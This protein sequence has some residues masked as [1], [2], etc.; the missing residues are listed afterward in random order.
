MPAALKTKHEGEFFAVDIGSTVLKIAQVAPD[1]TL[2]AQA[3]NNRDY[4]AEIVDQLGD[5]LAPLGPRI[6]SGNLVICSSA[7]GGLRVGIVSLSGS[8]SGSTYR[9]QVLLGGANPIYLDELSNPNRNPGY[10]DILLVGG[11]IDCDDA[12]AMRALLQNFVPENYNFGA[13]LYAGNRF[14]ADEFKRR[15]PGAVVIDNPMS[16][17]L[18][19]VSDSIFTALRDAYLDDLVY[20]QG[21]TEVAGKYAGIVRPTPEVVNAGYY[22]AISEQKFPQLTGASILVDAGGA[23][24]D[25]HYTVEVIRDDSVHRPSPGSS[26]ARYVFTD[27]GVFKSRDSTVLQLRR[28]PRTFEFLDAVLDSDISN[29]YRLLREGEYDPPAE[30]LAYA[31]VFLSLDRFSLGSGPGLPTADLTKLN[32]LVLTGGAAQMLEE[33]KVAAIASLFL[34]TTVDA[35]F[36]MIDR[37]YEIWV[38]GALS[39]RQ[40]ANR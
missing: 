5:L 13:L 16:D 34:P 2:L 3:F 26:V 30:L 29:V 31:C 27:L 35:D 37:Q 18:S 12:T 20:K 1:G 19:I 40:A 17:D 33:G 14:L 25:F 7:N 22:K 39:H 23:T 32:K 11:G 8:Y 4:D 21:V 36:I 24:T 15:H 38:Q 9:N 6:N 10:V 28:N